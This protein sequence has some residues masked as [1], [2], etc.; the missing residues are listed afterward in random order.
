[1]TGTRWWVISFVMG[2]EGTVAEVFGG[3]GGWEW[4]WNHI[5]KLNLS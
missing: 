1:M 3:C 4:E 2:V 5:G